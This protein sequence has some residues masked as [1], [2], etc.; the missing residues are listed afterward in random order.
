MEMYG[1]SGGKGFVSVLHIR[2][3]K[4]MKSGYDILQATT[5]SSFS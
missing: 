4:L 1:D 3:E 2:N 5:I